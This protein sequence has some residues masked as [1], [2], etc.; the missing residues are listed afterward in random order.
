M[1]DDNLT[2]AIA[3]TGEE[4]RPLVGGR[5]RFTGNGVPILEVSD[6][7]AEK[8]TEARRAQLDPSAETEYLVGTTVVMHNPKP[9][10]AGLTS[11]ITILHIGGE[12]LDEAAKTCIGTFEGSFGNAPPTWVASTSDDLAEVIADHYAC[13][14]KGM[15]EELAP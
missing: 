12:T 15:D 5:S 11:D 10:D 7:V 9:Q 8:I 14:V 6:A 2:H 13:S 3:S 1:S 4:T